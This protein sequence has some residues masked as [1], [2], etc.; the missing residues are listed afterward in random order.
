M[1]KLKESL[2]LLNL[3]LLL[4]LLFLGLYNLSRI[5]S[6]STPKEEEKVTENQTTSDKPIEGY[7]Q[8][9]NSFQ[10]VK[11]IYPQDWTKKEYTNLVFVEFKKDP[12]WDFN[13][14]SEPLTSNPSLEEYK[15]KA[16]NLIKGYKNYQFLDSKEATLSGLPGFTITFLATFDKGYK[17][18]QIYTVKQ[19]HG[20]SL[21]YRSDPEHFDE[22]LPEAD[23]MMASFAII[24]E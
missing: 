6:L 1:H 4:G 8:Y 23:K 9:V 22:Q 5:N 20:Y 15:E 24:P 10:K 18:K 2:P 11:M 21:T 16:L 7:L 3:V 12:Y 17:I 13:I 19:N 14:V